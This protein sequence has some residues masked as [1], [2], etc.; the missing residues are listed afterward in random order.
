MPGSSLTNSD[1]RR[2]SGK[3]AI[4]GVDES[5][6]IGVVPSKSTLQ[7]HAE[8]ARNALADAGIDMSD[9]DGLFTAGPGWSP[10]LQVAEYLG[11]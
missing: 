2:L 3:V 11:I 5:D 8:A 9:V 7:L 6:E 10:S 1:R 4:V